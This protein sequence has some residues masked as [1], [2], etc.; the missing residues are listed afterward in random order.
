[1]PT[2]LQRLDRPPSAALLDTLWCAAVGLGQLPADGEHRVQRGHRVLE[3]HRDAVAAQLAQLSSR[4]VR[5][6]LLPPKRMEPVICAV[7]GSRPMI[8]IEDTDL[9][10]PDSPTMPSTS[11]VQGEGHV[12]D[13][14][15]EA[16]VGGEPDR[17][18]LHLEHLGGAD[19]TPGAR[20]AAILLQRRWTV[21][22][23]RTARPGPRAPAR[24]G[25][26]RGSRSAGWWGERTSGTH[27]VLPRVEGIPQAVADEVDGQRDDDDEQARPP[28][29]PWSGIQG[30]LVVRH[31][32]TQ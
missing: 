31:Q 21:R 18:V 22:T 16:V 9:P 12:A 23:P 13:R 6:A 32:Q 11:R 19:P 2:S 1:M 5:R 8:A 30:V 3:D 15:D 26:R 20:P 17:E 29:Q 27:P 14:V 25:C 24:T 7:V 28:E 10:E 4:A